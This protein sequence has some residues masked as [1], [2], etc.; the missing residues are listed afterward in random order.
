MFDGVVEYFE[1]LMVV[2]VLHLILLFFIA[3]FLK[4]L[5]GNKKDE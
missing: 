1:W 3:H 4:K 5:V 2:Q